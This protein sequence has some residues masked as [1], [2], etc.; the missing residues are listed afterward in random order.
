ML[1]SAAGLASDTQVF[2][3]KCGIEAEVTDS[4]TNHRL[5]AA[6]DERAGTKA[7]RGGVGKWSDVE[8]AFDF[9][10]QRLRSRLQKEREK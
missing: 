4:L 3:G 8:E 1:S 6:V 10:A 7:L 2:V 9:W 5:A